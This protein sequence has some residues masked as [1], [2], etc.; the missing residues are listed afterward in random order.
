MNPE[1]AL[2]K[3]PIHSSFSF[4]AKIFAYLSL[5]KDLKKSDFCKISQ[6]KC[7]NNLPL[8]SKL[9]EKTTPQG[10]VHAR[11]SFLKYCH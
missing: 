1:N 10:L 3:R 5:C 7:S 9:M 8:I 2:I 6:D 4:P 11:L